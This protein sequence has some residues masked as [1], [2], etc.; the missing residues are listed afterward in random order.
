MI[1]YRQA[2]A[3]ALAEEMRRDPAVIL[4]GQEVGP[5]GGAFAASESIHKEFGNDRVIDTPIS[6][7]SFVGIGVGAAMTGLRP[8]V[9]LMFSDFL[10]L[11]MDQLVNHAA[12]IHYMYD[13]QVT[14]PLVLRT[15][16]GGY[17]GYGASHSQT[18]AGWLMNV[19]GIKIAAPFT[20]QDAYDLLRAAIRDDNPVVVF[21][22]KLLY[23]MKGN[24]AESAPIPRLGEARIL[25]PGKHVTLVGYSYVLT[26][27]LEAAEELAAE[28]IEVEVIDLRTLKPMDT[29]TLFESVR[30]TGRMVVV[31]EGPRVGGVGAEVAA[32]VAETCLPYL[33]GR[34]VRVGAEDS[35][36]AAGIELEQALLP[37]REKI[38]AACRHSLKW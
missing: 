12:K 8:V 29:E 33:D 3:R 35:P 13:G 34:I 25:R 18:P 27:A 23:G 9:E 30:R 22:H 19:P 21:E 10:A 37:S 26:L 4:M 5:M 2:V 16:M 14:V 31:E 24:V 11:A 36:L 17:R 20:P 15:P 32:Q 6:E 28:G 1:L 38:A 7:N